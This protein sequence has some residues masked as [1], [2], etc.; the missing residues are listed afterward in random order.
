MAIV[1]DDK[2]RPVLYGGMPGVVFTG[3]RRLTPD[4][5]WCEG[6]RTKSISYH[7]LLTLLLL[8]TILQGKFL[9]P[10]FSNESR[11]LGEFVT[12]K[13][14]TVYNQA[15]LDVSHLLV[16]GRITEIYVILWIIHDNFKNCFNHCS[17]SK[18]YKFIYSPDSLVHQ[19]HDVCS[20]KA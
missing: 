8:F 3:C 16:L 17:L 14:G 20:E 9:N 7:P 2:C 19:L 4:T 6:G 13:S 10:G 1:L 15:S 5:V 11:W 12:T 18:H